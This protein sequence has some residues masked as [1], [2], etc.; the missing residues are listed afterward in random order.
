[1]MMESGVIDFGLDESNEAL[2]RLI[3]ELENRELRYCRDGVAVF[4]GALAYRKGIWLVA[5]KAK[6]QVTLEKVRWN[7]NGSAYRLSEFF[8]HEHPTVKVLDQLL[9][10]MK[11]QLD[12][13][14]GSRCLLGSGRLGSVFRVCADDGRS[15]SSARAHGCMALK[16]VTGFENI[17]KLERE[18]GNNQAICRRRPGVMVEAADIC[19]A[20]PIRSSEIPGD[21]TVGAGML[22]AEVGSKVSWAD[23]GGLPR[24]LRA[25]ADL[26]RAGWAH[27]SARPDNLLACGDGFKWCD[28]QRAECLGGDSS[29]DAQGDDSDADAGED[30]SA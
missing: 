6:N 30:D 1:M 25:L 14:S 18:F 12:D 4:K 21:Y 28:A 17:R 20:R 9:L 11:L 24:A 5:L 27:G 7:A 13:R 2:C 8:V 10:D 22:M 26:H 15:P 16:V 19:L 23:R 3:I 29:G